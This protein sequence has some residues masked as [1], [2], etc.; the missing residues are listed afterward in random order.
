MLV[1]S[2]RQD[3]ILELVMCRDIETQ[4]ELL[5][6]LKQSGFNS[7]QATVSRD[8]KHL[9][10]IKIPFGDGKYK[11]S[12]SEKK[13]ESVQSNF[14]SVISSSIVSVDYAMNMVVIKSATGMAQGVCA[15][16]DSKHL[17]GVIGTLAGDDTIFIVAK[18][19]LRAS[20]LVCELE[21]MIA[22]G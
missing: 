8:I 18:D 12:V 9:R 22:G 15:L 4:E 11:Y 1:R 20:A 3:K 17:D 7:T 2:K 19:E 5:S 10:L 14:L 13:S 16:L 6:L 21:S